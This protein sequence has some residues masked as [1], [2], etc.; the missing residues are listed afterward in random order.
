MPVYSS[1]LVRYDDLNLG[2]RI[3]EER[4]RQGWTLK[5]LSLK[6][7]ISI[8]RLSEIETGRHLLD[9]HQALAIG[10]ALSIRPESFL[11]PDVTLPYQISR[12]VEVRS[13]PPRHVSIVGKHK[14][15]GMTH[16][17]QFWP[18][19]DLFVGRHVEPV[20]GRIMP[21]A[22]DSLHYCYHHAEEFVFVL[23]GTI[24]FRLR[25]AEGDCSEELRRGDCIYFRS[26][27]PHLLRSLDEDPAESIHVFCTAP[28]PIE[29]GIDWLAQS[30]VLYI[31]HER[32]NGSAHH[33]GERLKVLR[34][35]HGWSTSQVAE[36][37][38]LTERKLSRIENGDRAVPLA[39]ILSLARAFGKPLR[40]LVG[41]THAGGPYYFV[42]RSADIPSIPSRRRRTPVERPN[43]PPSKTCQPLASG[44]AIRNMYPYFIRLLNVDLETLTLHEHHGQEF[45]YVLENELEL[46]TYAEDKQVQEILGPGDSCYIDSSVPHLLRGR[47]RNPYSQTTAEVLDVFCCPLGEGYLF[48]D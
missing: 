18:L 13:R 41:Q 19:A 29:T 17:N 3:R 25:S 24:E 20:L 44:F 14:A 38:G 40:E 5:D 35:M 28:A 30:P 16:H 34:E 7:S 27:V 31:E 8:A 12:D 6:V 2:Q 43:V 23:K 9:L 47:T 37:S 39:A 22:D 15:G 36:V 32:G 33:I 1:H 45:I 10:E 11:P 4:R 48:G 46:T 21:T 26:D 42:Q